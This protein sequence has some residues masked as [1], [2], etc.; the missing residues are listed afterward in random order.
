MFYKLISRYGLWK[1]RWITIR[2]ADEDGANLGDIYIDRPSKW[3]I[4]TLSS[5]GI[6]DVRDH[7]QCIYLASFIFYLWCSETVVW[8]C[9]SKFVLKGCNFIKKRLQHRCFPVKFENFFNN[10]FLQ[11]ISGGC[12]CMLYFFFYL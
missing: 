7:W 1:L 8:R 2:G 9:Y 4:N 11:N 3:C 10:T 5:W 6:R 12:F